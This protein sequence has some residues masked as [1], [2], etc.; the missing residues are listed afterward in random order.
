[1][2]EGKLTPVQFEIMQL[3]WAAERGLTIGEIWESMRA[4]RE[5]SRTTTLNLVDRL[6]K[7]R[8]LRRRKVDGVYRYTARVARPSVEARLASDFLTEFFDG[9]AANLMMSLL[10]SRQITPDELDR[11]RALIQDSG[12]SKPPSEDR[13]P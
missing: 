12:A 1:M 9:S 10:G 11:L 3:V 8:W 13:S 2:P 6:E 5:V 7:R 4:A